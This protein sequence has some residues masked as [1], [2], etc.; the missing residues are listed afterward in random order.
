[1]NNMARGQLTSTSRGCL[2]N[3]HRTMRIAFLLYRR[4]SSTPDGAGDATAED[5]VIVGRIHNCVDLLLNQVAG[6]DHDSRRMHSSTSAT[7]S[8]NCL[9]VAFAMPFTPTDEMVIDAHAAPH[10]SASLR[11]PGW[12]PV[13]SQR[14]IIPPAS[15]SPAPVESTTGL[16]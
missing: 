7:R 6:D 9:C 4:P 1:M 8:F 16:P 15:A 13:L 3:F 2:A 11:P 10:T 14:A 5:E 12:P